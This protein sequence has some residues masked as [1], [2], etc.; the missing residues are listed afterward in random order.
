MMD[1]NVEHLHAYQDE[2]LPRLLQFVG[3]CN[4]LANFCGYIHPGDMLHLLSNGLRGQE[5][6]KHCY[7]YETAEEGILGLVLLYPARFSAYQ[8]LIHP[9]HRASTL[10]GAL[11]LWAEQQ[12]RTLLAAAS[13]KRSLIESDVMDCDTTRRDLLHQQGY[14]AEGGPNFYYTTRSL[15]KPVPPS[16]LPDGF[17]I[18]SVAGEHEADAVGVVHASAFHSTWQTGEYLHVMRTRGFHIDRE[19]VV[20]APNGRFAAFLVYWI[21]AVSK[22][23][24]F[25]PVGCHPD[26][27]RRGLTSAL[28]YEGM[29]RMLSQGMSMAI[30]LHEP[31]QKNPASA[32]LYRSIG[33]K[34]TYTI[35]N[36]H[37]QAGAQ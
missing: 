1:F 36:Y 27:Q 19:L 31:P 9:H 10:E 24:L 12:T 34:V 11:L 28:M 25:E 16:L 2:E 8:V 5:S 26:F 22:S 21:D 23:G 18:R 4:L 33:F 3:E 30:V 6:E 7:F 37:K 17:V 15:M 32:A 20:V 29:R 13:S 14:H 35:T